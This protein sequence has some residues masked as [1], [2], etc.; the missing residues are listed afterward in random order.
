MAKR[1]LL[2]SGKGWV[3]GFKQ[4]LFGHDLFPNVITFTSI[5][6]RLVRHVYKQHSSKP[7]KVVVMFVRMRNYGLNLI[8]IWPFDYQVIK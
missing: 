4:G 6:F 3:K 5:K 8:F 7:V 1:G 2:R